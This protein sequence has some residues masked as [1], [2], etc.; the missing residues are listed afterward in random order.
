MAYF[1]FVDNSNVW[2][3]GKVASAVTKGQ[4]TTAVEAHD[5]GVEDG[6]W[7]IDFGKLLNYVVEGNLSDIKCSNIY[8]SVPPQNDSLWAAATAANFAVNTEERNAANKEKRVDTNIVCDVMENLYTE[9]SEGDI[10]VLVV[11]DGD[12]IPAVERIKKANRMVYV[13]FWNNISNELRAKADKFIDLTPDIA[14]ITYV[15]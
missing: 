2:I 1:V 15:G 5:I 8:G 6:G 7:R 11:G 9:S 12:Y 14:R 10:F 4:A 13:A 3:E